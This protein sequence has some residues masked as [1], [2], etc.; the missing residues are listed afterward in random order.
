MFALRRMGY[1]QQEATLHG[2]R[3]TA[4]T[5]LNELGFRSDIIEAQLAHRDKNKVRAAY[6]RAVYIEE[7]RRKMMQAWAGYLDTLKTNR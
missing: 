7:E 3:T 1:T 5:L 6:N 4:S 2:F